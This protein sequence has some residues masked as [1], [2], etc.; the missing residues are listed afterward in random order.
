MSTPRF[1]SLPGEDVGHLL[2]LEIVVGEERERLVGVLDA[3]VGTLEVEAGRD[4][5]VGLVDR[6]AHF[7]L[8]H[9]GDD[10]ERRHGAACRKNDCRSLQ[11]M[12]RPRKRTRCD[13]A[14]VSSS[15]ER[16]QLC[17]GAATARGRR[18]DT[19]RVWQRAQ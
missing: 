18:G 11:P 12:A 14:S 8:I 6:V 15:I 16:G 17:A 1:V 9:F 5:L 3:G 10:I 13:A 7:D 4:F 2:Q 19:P